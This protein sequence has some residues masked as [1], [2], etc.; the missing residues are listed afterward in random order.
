MCVK[1][2]EV[3]AHE[4]AAGANG[5]VASAAAMFRQG[6]VGPGITDL[7]SVKT[8][9]TAKPDQLPETYG[10]YSRQ[11]YEKGITDCSL[12]YTC[13][14]GRGFNEVGFF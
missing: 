13:H 11:V 7:N 5:V 14:Y 8:T 4:K 3:V 9:I 10:P 6:A 12:T 2:T 1:P